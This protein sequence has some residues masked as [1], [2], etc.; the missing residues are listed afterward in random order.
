MRVRNYALL[1]VL[2]F[3]T[4]SYAKPPSDEALAKVALP[5]EQLNAM[6]ADAVFRDRATPVSAFVLGI[7]PMCKLYAAAADKSVARHLPQWRKNLLRAFRD[8]VPPQALEQA[9]GEGTIGRNRLGQYM[10][11]IGAVMEQSSGALLKQSTADVL[12][13]IASASASVKIGD[14]DQDARNRELRAHVAKTGKLCG[15]VNAANS[16]VKLESLN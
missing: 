10:N 1:G 14:I 7:E 12:Q 15:V 9:V 6:L 8:I 13:E 11:Q 3:A 5:K 2:L 16:S 4:A